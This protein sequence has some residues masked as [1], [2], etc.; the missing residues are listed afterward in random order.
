MFNKFQYGSFPKL[1]QNTNIFCVQIAKVVLS[2]AEEVIE[3][4]GDEAAKL[5]SSSQV[6]RCSDIQLRNYS[7]KNDDGNEGNE[8]SQDS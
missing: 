1:S 5:L 6:D 4:E 3:L 7:H 2:T 8:S